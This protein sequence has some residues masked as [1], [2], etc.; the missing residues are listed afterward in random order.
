MNLTAK[1]WEI[2]SLLLE[3]FGTG[4]AHHFGGSLSCAEL[5]A[6]LYF[7]KMKYS[8]ELMNSPERDRFIMSKG[9]ACRHST[10]PWRCWG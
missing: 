3:M 10:L 9:T 2:R 8:K 4:K 1:A 6:C 5:I 7:Y